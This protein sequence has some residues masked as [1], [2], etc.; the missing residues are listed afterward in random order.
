MKI[1]RKVISLKPELTI[2][3]NGSAMVVEAAPAVKLNRLKEFQMEIAVADPKHTWGIIRA[4]NEKLFGEFPAPEIHHQMLML[5]IQY[6]LV[7]LDYVEQKIPIPT[8]LAQNVT[9]SKHYDIDSLVPSLKGIM[10]SLTK[11]EN[12]ATT[13]V[14]KTTT[15]VNRIAPA[16]VAKKETVTQTYFRLFESN[17]TAQLTDA[18]LALKMCQAHPD[19]KKYTVEDIASIRGMYNRGKLAIQKGKPAM[20]AFVKVAAK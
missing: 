19:K 3:K 1:K 11:G 10:E 2:S 20:E 18:Q 6:E 17:K 4:W 9:A 13:T 7:R 5:R 12:M 15:P 16:P 8:R 14:K